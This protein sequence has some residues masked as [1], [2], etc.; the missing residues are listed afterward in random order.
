[1]PEGA[2]PMGDTLLRQ[3]CGEFREDGVSA[4]I[5]C[6][7]RRRGRRGLVCGPVTESGLAHM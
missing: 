3:L 4:P 7:L 6:A 5:A 2:A 1:M